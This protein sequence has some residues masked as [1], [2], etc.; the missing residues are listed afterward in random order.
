[1]NYRE[2]A[3]GCSGFIPTKWDTQCANCRK[4]ASQHKPE[5]FDKE[6]LAKRKEMIEDKLAKIEE[7]KRKQ[8]V[9]L[10]NQVEY[11]KTF[12]QM[13]IKGPFPTADFK[14]DLERIHIQTLLFNDK[15]IPLELLE[16]IFQHLEF[17]DKLRLR[18]VSVAVYQK[19]KKLSPDLNILKV[20][21]NILSYGYEMKYDY[22]YTIPYRM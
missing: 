17:K 13:I 5:D 3:T 1:M 2:K 6:L 10:A 14:G 7:K 16:N 22:E 19:L 21:S 8:E 20:K 15:T 4:Y 12:Q 9:D 11:D 18:L